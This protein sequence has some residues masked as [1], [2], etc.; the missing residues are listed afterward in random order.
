M[1]EVLERDDHG[2]LIPLLDESGRQFRDNEGNPRFVTK[3]D[4]SRE[5][6]TAYRPP[7]LHTLRWLASRLPH[8]QEFHNVALLGEDPIAQDSDRSPVR[9]SLAAVSYRE[10]N[11]ISPLMASSLDSRGSGV[12]R[13]DPGSALPGGL[14][15]SGFS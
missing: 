1:K 15:F 4:P 14:R 13:A 2:R 9:V 3:L 7:D 6:D 10:G 12:V 8:A 11:H 5:T